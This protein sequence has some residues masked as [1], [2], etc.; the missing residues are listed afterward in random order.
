MPSNMVWR[1]STLRPCGIATSAFIHQYK[2][3]LIIFSDL[4]SDAYSSVAHNTIQIA[5]I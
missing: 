3:L 5:E 2:F 1:I 4:D